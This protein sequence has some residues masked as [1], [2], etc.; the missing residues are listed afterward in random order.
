MFKQKNMGIDNVGVGFYQRICTVS[1]NYNW[2]QWLM[3]QWSLYNRQ[4]FRGWNS[5]EKYC[6]GCRS[7]SLHLRL[8]IS[9]I[10]ILHVYSCPGHHVPAPILPTCSRCRLPANGTVNKALGSTAAKS[11]LINKA[12]ALRSLSP[13]RQDRGGFGPDKEAVGRLAAPRA[14][15]TYHFLTFSTAWITRLMSSLARLRVS[16]RTERDIILAGWNESTLTRGGDRRLSGEGVAASGMSYYD[17]GM[18]HA[19]S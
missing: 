7:S 19:K 13:C 5:T 9:V 6:H 1:S 8:T 2:R 12:F 3:S 15:I 14:V 4:S 16:A 17:V 18:P 11:Q 10:T